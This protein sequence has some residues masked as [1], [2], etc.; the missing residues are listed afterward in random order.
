MRILK[1]MGTVC[2]A[3]TDSLTLDDAAL[4]RAW[5]EAGATAGRLTPMPCA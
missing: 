4:A 3:A 5:S 2:A 1:A